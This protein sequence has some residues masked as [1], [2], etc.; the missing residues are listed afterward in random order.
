MSS[1]NPSVRV[2]YI[3]RRPQNPSDDAK[4]ILEAKK[5]IRASFGNRI[6]PFDL[7]I[8]NW[9]T[10][11]NSGLRIRRPDEHDL[12]SIRIDINLR[13]EP[14]DGKDHLMDALN[15]VGTPLGLAGECHEKLLEANAG[16]IIRCYVSFELEPPSTKSSTSKKS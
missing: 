5:I 11:E 4:V 9:Y 16:R 7:N 15:I 6:V 10:F 8:Y 12:N 1:Y 14:V 2:I 3:I 13:E